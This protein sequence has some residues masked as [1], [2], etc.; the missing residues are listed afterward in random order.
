M[1]RTFTDLFRQQSWL[2]DNGMDTDQEDEAE[3]E[4]DD[5]DHGPPPAKRQKSSHVYQDEFG[6][7]VDHMSDYPEAVD[8]NAPMQF[9]GL[10][11]AYRRQTEINKRELLHALNHSSSSATEDEETLG[12]DASLTEDSSDSDTES[13]SANDQR[14]ARK[15]RRRKKVLALKDFNCFLCAFGNKLHDGVYAPVLVE[16][17]QIFQDLY[18]RINDID[19]AKMMVA[20]FKKRIRGRDKSIPMITEVSILDHIQGL[21]TLN[22]TMFVVQRIRTWKKVALVLEAKL[23]N[24]DGTVNQKN[25][26]E[27]KEAELR[28][29]RL[30]LMDIEKMNFQG[31]LQLDTKKMGAVCEVMKKFDLRG[32]NRR[33]RRHA[34]GECRKRKRKDL[35]S[36]KP[37]RL[38]ESLF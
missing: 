8:V 5:D 31:D 24:A 21:H 15:K 26:K 30:Y 20:F 27:L 1:A 25:L 18:A 16:F 9:C 28:L 13:P 19:L 22:A 35:L 3:E 11:N 36:N 10:D 23:F 2:C 29:D 6:D 12:D 32:A 33:T 34:C 7:A 14:R 4:M 38:A 17:I 37:P